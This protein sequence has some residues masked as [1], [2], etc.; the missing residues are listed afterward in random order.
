LT[1]NY[2]KLIA[3]QVVQPCSPF[4]VSRRGVATEEPI[5][6]EHPS[7]PDEVNAEEERRLRA[8]TNPCDRL[9]PERTRRGIATIFSETAMRNFVIAALAILAFA[10]FVTSAEAGWRAQA[11]TVP[12]PFAQELKSSGQ[13]EIESSRL[14]LSRTQN[15]EIKKFAQKMID[16]HTAADQKLSETMKQANLPEPKY[17]MLEKTRDLLKKL[18]VLHGANFDRAYV[19]EQI[20]GHKGVLELLEVYSKQGRND[21]VRQ[22]ASTLLPTIKEHL[23]MAE[24]LRSS[25]TAR[26]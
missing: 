11:M 8:G 5:T 22:L 25:A 10:G 17:G 12:G 14:A 23:Q 3:E 2:R 16:D 18:T 9:F 20:Q 26:R 21:A 15:E 13:F 19:R 1:P 4:E 7:G 24:G 6:R